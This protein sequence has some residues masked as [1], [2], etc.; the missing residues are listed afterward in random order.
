MGLYRL[1]YGWK[2][3]CQKHAE[4]G[5]CVNMYWFISVVT[6]LRYCMDACYYK[7]QLGY[8]LFT[9]LEVSI[10]CIEFIVTYI[11]LKHIWEKSSGMYITKHVA[12][13]FLFI[14]SFIGRGRIPAVGHKILLFYFLVKSQYSI[15]N[16][17]AL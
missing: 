15:Q 7:E 16:L 13:S 3:I 14:T 9:R 2:L 17:I 11:E 5:H 1:K 6:V 4:K 12:L 8:W 10:S